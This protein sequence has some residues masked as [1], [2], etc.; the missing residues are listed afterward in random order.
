MFSI[1]NHSLIL[2]AIGIILFSFHKKSEAM[3][4]SGTSNDPYLIY[5]CT[6]LQNMQS[7]LSA[8]YELANDIDCSATSSWNGGLGFDPVG[9]FRGNFDGKGFV[10]S[11]LTINR[12]SEDQVGL[13][14]YVDYA[15]N[16]R[17][18]V[19]N[20]GIENAS[21]T[22]RNFVG[23]L[24]GDLSSWDY[25]VK[26]FNTYT[27]GT[28]SGNNYVGGLVGSYNRVTISQSFSTASV[29][30]NSYVGGL[31][32]R[33]NTSSK[34]D[35]SYAV[36]VVSGA[37]N[38]GGLTGNSSGGDTK[39][40]WDT[41]SSGR[42]T[43]GVGTG[44]TT[45][46]MKTESTFTGSNTTVSGEV[47]KTMTNP[48]S[49]SP[50]VVT[51]SSV[52][53]SNYSGWKAFNDDDYHTR[54]WATSAAPTV[55]SPQWLKIDT[56]FGNLHT[57]S[58]YVILPRNWNL[59][60]APVDWT[61]EG[62]DDDNIW[63]EIDQ[64][65]GISGWSA[66]VTKSFSLSEPVQYRYYRWVFTKNNGNTGYMTIGNIN[67]NGTTTSGW[68]F[69][70]VWGIN[71]SVNDGYPY[72]QSFVDLAVIN[73]TKT[74]ALS[75]NLVSGDFSLAAPAASINFGSLT[76][77]GAVQNLTGNLGTLVVADWRGTEEGWHVTVSASPFTQSNTG[78]NPALTL[79]VGSLAL[80]GVN[81]I[82]QTSGSSV[83]PS[84]SGGS[85]WTIDN[86]AVTLLSANAGEGVGTFDITFPV[87]VLTLTIDTKNQLVDPDNDPTIY[88]STIT[89]TVNAGP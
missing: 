4:G 47:T 35:R 73:Q 25:V 81:T 37:S 61:F 2:I 59:D 39:S 13:F 45:I 41:E 80:S 67:L 8:L 65:V 74:T 14:S 60:E 32:G 33:Q 28:V 46:Q 21:I 36:G 7:N 72:L 24:T 5:D 17:Y 42:A 83:L 52:Y 43:S 12:P 15:S 18:H 44:K 16:E 86:G 34:T 77:D 27:T 62:S 26:V 49:P 66:G 88:E 54:S 89:W 31:A 63:V 79:P 71:P 30:G 50:F 85:P 9:T 3:T 82:T 87:S 1:K 40:Y 19:A 10:I 58:E 68:D 23:S 75:L 20:V 84:A 76:V 69:A 38:V 11:N 22:G 78:V 70:T 64:Q 53:S 56:G 55:G 29:T 6:D 51:A 57:I 48:I